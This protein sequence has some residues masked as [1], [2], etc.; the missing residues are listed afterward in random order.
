MQHHP[1]EIIIPHTTWA[2]YWH[3]RTQTIRCPRCGLVGAVMREPDFYRHATWFFDCPRRDCPV[4]GNL[5]GLESAWRSQT[6]ID[7]DGLEAR[8]WRNPN[9][10]VVDWEKNESDC[11]E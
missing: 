2:P 1:H 8:G 3:P 4:R 7:L 9:D 11:D 6:P 5:R 10:A